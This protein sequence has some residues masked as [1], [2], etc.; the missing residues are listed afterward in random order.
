ML[1]SRSRAQC[2]AAWSCG[3]LLEPQNGLPVRSGTSVKIVWRMTG[4]GPLR[5]T[6]VSPVGHVLLPDFGPE[7]HAGSSWTCPGDEWGSAFTFHSPGCWDVQLTCSTVT[8]HVW[9]FVAR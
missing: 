3:G 9:L 6:A 5:L 1:R 8:G 2:P 4:T 7:I